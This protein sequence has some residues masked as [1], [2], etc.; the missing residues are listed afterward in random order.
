MSERVWIRD[1]AEKAGAKVEWDAERKQV[2]IDGRLYLTPGEIRDGKAY[3]KKDV[4]DY[5]LQ[6]LGYAPPDRT[7]PTSEPTKEMKEEEERDRHYESLTS[8]AIPGWSEIKDYIYQHAYKP[9]RD[10]VVDHVWQPVVNWVQPFVESIKQIIFSVKSVWVSIGEFL[11]KLKI[12]IRDSANS[13]RQTIIDWASPAVEWVKGKVDYLEWLIR[14]EVIIALNYLTNQIHKFVWLF[15]VAFDRL[16]TIL[17]APVHYIADAVV[18][19][20]EY[21][22][23]RI[24]DLVEDY[25]V[26]YWDEE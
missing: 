9:I 12:S 17:E 5:A 15:T 11:E 13:V 18:A 4:I 19:G 26:K 6:Y 25:I 3:I 1:Y 21:W 20:F 10:W 7:P 23:E 24:F 8:R 16:Y 2:V 14:H 22:C